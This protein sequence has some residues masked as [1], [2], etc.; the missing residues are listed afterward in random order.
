MKRLLLTMMILSGAITISAQKDKPQDERFSPE[1]FEAELH[2]FIVKEA[3]LNQ[4][5]EAL[6]FPIY[7]EMQQKQ[8]AIFDQQRNL[9]R[10]KPSDEEACMKAIKERDEKEIELKRIQQQYHKRFLELMPATKVW[11][12]LKA[13]ERFHRRAMQNWGQKHNPNGKRPAGQRPAGQ[14]HERPRTMQK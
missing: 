7:R 5:E 3:H 11:D 10:Q 2:A 4:Q 12:I 14:R 9:G 6:F 1:K 13:E 8:R